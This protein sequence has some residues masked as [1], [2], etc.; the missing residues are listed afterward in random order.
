[1]SSSSDL[2]Q[3]REGIDRVDAQI[4]GLLGERAELVKQI[5]EV[6]RRAGLPIY[7]PE[8]ERQ[9]L[10]RLA[11]QAPA[12]IDPE[13]VQRVFERIIDESRRL[14]RDHPLCSDG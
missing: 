1:V 11:E 3:L 8:R 4:L 13:F 7:D 10:A 2:P 14:E 12:S 6:K 9:V 5:G